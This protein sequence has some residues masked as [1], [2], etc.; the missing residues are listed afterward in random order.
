MELH[1]EY[2]GS[3]AAVFLWQYFPNT[4]AVVA[5]I[6]PL[7]KLD[8]ETTP[9]KQVSTIKDD[10]SMSP[11]KD[12]VSYSFTDKSFLYE[13]ENKLASSKLR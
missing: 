7:Q 3:T 9:L 13:E 8:A 2:Y 6:L 1:L 11:E 12:I 10:I 5:I 4:L